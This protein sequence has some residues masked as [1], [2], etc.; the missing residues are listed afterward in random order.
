MNA[1]NPKNNKNIP[2][3]GESYHLHDYI[4]IGNVKNGLTNNSNCYLIDVFRDLLTMKPYQ[5]Y[6]KNVL[7]AKNN[8]KQ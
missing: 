1:T 4:V 7:N 6:K 2:D 5:W 3:D 8:K